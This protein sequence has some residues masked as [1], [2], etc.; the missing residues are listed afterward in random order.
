MRIKVICVVLS[1]FFLYSCIKKEGRGGGDI[2]AGPGVSRD[3]T[4]AD[5]CDREDPLFMEIMQKD[6]K[7][8][9]NPLELMRYYT[10]ILNKGTSH[11]EI[12]GKLDRLFLCGRTPGEVDGFYHGITISL[13]TGTDVYTFLEKTRQ[14]LGIGR[15]VDMLQVLYGRLLSDTSPW[16]GKDFRKIGPEKVKKFTGGAVPGGDTVYLGINSFRKEKNGVVNNLSNYVLSAVIDME[17]VP[18]A[19]KRQR[20]WIHARGG[21]FLARKAMS[22]DTAHPGKEVLALNYRWKNLGNVFPNRLLIDEIVEISK[23]LYLGKLYYATSLKYL[24]K[25]YDPDVPV[26]DYK[27]RNF[28]YFLLMDDTWLGEKNRLFPEIAYSLSQDLS[29]K[30]RT[31]TFRDS[32]ECRAIAEDMGDRE[33][34]LH[35]LRDI[36]DGIQKGPGYKERYFARL[37]EVFKCGESPRGISGF[38]HGGV[39]SFNNGGFLKKFDRTVLN[40][41]YPAVRPFSPW[42]G[43]TFTPS[44]VDGIRKYIGDSARYYE[45]MNPVII[46]ANTYRKDLGL[47]LPVT[48]FIELL[49]RTGMIVEYPDE[50]EKSDDI[51]VKSFY[52]IAANSRSINP[53]NGGREVLQFNYRWPE[54]HT[55]PPDNL[56]IDELVRIAD[57]LYLGQLLY[58]TKPGIPYDPAKD[59]AVYKY[60]NFGYFMLMD[61][62]WYAVREFIGFDTDR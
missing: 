12:A 34:I 36:Y 14:R 59:P 6:M 61:D 32:P 33:T 21:L 20:S 60:E 28:G 45:G 30:F 37:L 51:Y 54:L 1:V 31:F 5:T 11:G 50:K 35:Y 25:D 24:F 29:G 41:I 49:D 23:G 58:S 18:G 16:A 7:G 10:D 52:F 57:G 17:A 53:E 42:T 55:M 48:A 43:K 9:N 8:R 47:S 27:Y 40:D 38:L 2:P 56:C 15:E 39:V 46:G 44:S 62:D 26:K 3:F 22:V 4:L 19:D 13:K